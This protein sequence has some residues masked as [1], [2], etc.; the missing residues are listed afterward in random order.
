MLRPK[1]SRE[2][3][4]TLAWK[5]RERGGGREGAGTRLQTDISQA[6]E[7]GHVG[8]LGARAPTSPALQCPW[9]SLTCFYGFFFSF[10]VLPSVSDWH[11]LSLLQSLMYLFTESLTPQIFTNE[12]LRT[13]FQGRHRGI[14]RS[15]AHPLSQH[16]GN[17]RDSR[18][19]GPKS[20]S[21]SASGR[22][23]WGPGGSV[24]QADTLTPH[25]CTNLLPL[26]CASGKPSIQIC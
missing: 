25:R 21:P 18:G 20:S 23:G 10:Y 6:G 13:G 3:V 16:E 2:H 14:K 19:W 1:G 12:A 24:S 15:D 17:G 5:R 22:N 9:A 7:R 4:W 8:T 11:F 26:C